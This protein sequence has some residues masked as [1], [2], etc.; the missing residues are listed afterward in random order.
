MSQ[1]GQTALQEFF[2]WE[3]Q[4]WVEV[5]EDLASD[6]KAHFMPIQNLK[7]YFTA[8]DSKKLSKILA[9]VFK[10]DF[11]PIDPDLILRD[12]TAIFCILLRIGRGEY[13]EHFAQYEELSDRRLPFDPTN[14]PEEFLEADDDAGFL[15]SFCDKQRM[16]CVPIFDGHMLHKRFGRQRLLPITH[17]EPRGMDGVAEKYLVK[18]Y[19]PYNKLLSAGQDPVR[20][21]SRIMDTQQQ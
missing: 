2:R 11:P 3:S 20:L 12:H 5:V 1:R 15:Q 6:E 8:N 13:I 10:S 14:P 19:G 9:E 4:S 16:Y 18:L 17:K 21:I 7:T